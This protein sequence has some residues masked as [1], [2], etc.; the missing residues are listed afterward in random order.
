MWQ[1]VPKETTPQPSSG[2]YPDWKDL[3]AK[4]A[5]YR[6]AYCGLHESVMG[7]RRAY[8]IDHY[9]PRSRPEFASLEH[10]FSNLF[11]ACP[12]CNGFKGDDWPGD[13]QPDHS[14]IAYPDPSMVDY[15]N[16]FDIDLA[17]GTVSGRYVA[18]KYVQTRLYLNRPQLLA[19]RRLWHFDQQLD[20]LVTWLQEAIPEVASAP[21]PEEIFPT[22]VALNQLLV[23][24]IALQRR[25][26]GAVPYES[27][28]VRRP[29]TRRSQHGRKQQ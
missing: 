23:E 16:L 9:K 20:A 26:R 28:E 14:A 29:R 17:R 6:C 13:S 21:E 18:A 4:E 19:E 25:V 22:L 15:R 2:Q 3:I 11:Y 5:S 1:R 7:G 12:I 10:V 27:A 8:H 24:L